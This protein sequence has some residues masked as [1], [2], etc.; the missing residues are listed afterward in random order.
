[1]NRRKFLHL[2]SIGA[3]SVAAPK[4]IFDMG[5]NSAIYTPIFDDNLRRGLLVVSNRIQKQI[6]EIR[7]ISLI[8]P[9]SVDD[10][11]IGSVGEIW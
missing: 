1:M 8:Y 9:S 11:P 3:V 7:S 2:M 10:E 4:I 5:K 6:E